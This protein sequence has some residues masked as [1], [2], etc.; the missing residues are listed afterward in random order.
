MPRY[1]KKTVLAH[2]ANQKSILLMRY[3][4]LDKIAVKLMRDTITANQAMD[5]IAKPGA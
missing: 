4:Q 2:I 5:E 3:D 1:A